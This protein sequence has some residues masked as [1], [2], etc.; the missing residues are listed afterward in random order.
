M[1]ELLPRYG[2]AKSRSQLR[3][4]IA[5][6]KQDGAVH[7]LK[8]HFSW[9]TWPHQG[10]ILP[11]SFLYVSPCG[12]SQQRSHYE[13]FLMTKCLQFVASIKK[14]IVS[15]ED[16]SL[17][18]GI[19]PKRGSWQ[20]QSHHWVLSKGEASIVSDRPVFG[21]SGIWCAK[22]RGLVSS[23]FAEGWI[24]NLVL[25][26]TLPAM[27]CLNSEWTGLKLVQGFCLKVDPWPNLL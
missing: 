18:N 16:P 24:I 2:S 22:R 5:S 1:S 25:S 12:H 19:S 9:E 7:R 27:T 21:C 15:P 8:L 13:I 11:R 17:F 14:S 23:L 26:W 20:E 6:A 4:A 10:C 3:I